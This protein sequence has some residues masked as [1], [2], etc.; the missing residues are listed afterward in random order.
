M[1]HASLNRFYTGLLAL[2]LLCVTLPALAQNIPAPQADSSSSASPAVDAPSLDDLNEQLD[3]IRQ[4]VAV[5][6]NDDLLSGLRQAA[7]QV[8]KQADNL[9]AQQAVDIEHLNDQLNILGPV[10][11]DEAQNLTSQRKTLT[12]QKNALVSDERQTNTLS[13]SARDL[14]TQIFNLRRSLFDSQISTRT[15]SPLSSAFWSTLIRPTDDDLGRLNRLLVDVRQ[16]LTSA[17][18]PG[19]RM[20]FIS[21]V[22]GALLIWFVVRR[23][24]ERLLIWS[25]IRWLPEGRLRRSALAL[26]VGLSTVLTITVATSLLRWGIVSNAVLSNDVVNLLDQV[27]TLI[28][29]CAFILGLGR[30]LLMLPHASWRLPQ[31]PDEIATA[32]G[33]IPVVLALALMVIGTQERINSVIASSLAL[34][35]AVNGLTAL[36]VS[37][38][39]LYALVRYRRTRRRFGLERLSG[40]AGLIPFIVTVWVGLSLLALVSGYL[41]LAYFLAVKLLWVSVVASTAYLLIACFGDICETLLSPKQ[42]GGM[43]LGSAL[44]LSARHQAQAST[45]LAGIGRTLLLLTAVLLAFLPSGSSPGELLASFAQ[46]DVTSKSLGNLS[47][48]PSDI[49]MALVC[50]VVGLLGVR[51]LKEW[52]GER[53]LPETNM[54]AGMQASLVTLIGY[55]GFV[56]VVAVVMSTLK[57]SL[58]NLTWVVSALSVGIGFGLQAIVQNFI[59]GLILLTE[60]PVKVGDW[61]SLAGVEGDIRRI[62]VRATEIQMGD[63]STVIVPNSQFITQNV[64]NV[65]MGNALGVVGITLTLP[66]ETDVLQIRELLLQAFTEHEAILDA[67]APSVTFK[68]LTNTGLIISASGY[69]NSPRSVSGARSDLLFTVLGRLRELGVALSAPQSMVL[70]NEGAGKEATEE[71]VAT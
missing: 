46:L 33:R 25:M 54:D 24:L 36:A 44:G 6:A 30:A 58:T 29:F 38:V 32:M 5:S 56:L 48:V 9:I 28:T 68:D 40:F 20:Q 62:N 41:T 61:V 2:L 50:L 45:V 21:I 4:K 11:P 67:P 3:Q 55:I 63:R 57:I 34:T 66:L 10:Q 13:Q 51:V 35:V 39:F 7:L 23:L 70:I 8:Q 53:L 65:T 47:I 69:V 37:L 17:L 52:F 42:P 26:A 71:S 60:R 49:L 43:A 15:A 18:A 14:A 22:F 59:S 64:R 19:N 31:I 1:Q 12:T 16:V 27:Q